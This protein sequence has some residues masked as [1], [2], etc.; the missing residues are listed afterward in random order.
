ME[1]FVISFFTSD[2]D[3]KMMTVIIDTPKISRNFYGTF[4]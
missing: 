4:E 2:F 1:Y 3:E